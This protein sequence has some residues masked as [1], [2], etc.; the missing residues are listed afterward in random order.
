MAT[1]Q[2]AAIAGEHTQKAGTGNPTARNAETGRAR[3]I[4]ENKNAVIGLIFLHY[5]IPYKAF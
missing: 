5:K 2:R 1:T 4:L 3:T